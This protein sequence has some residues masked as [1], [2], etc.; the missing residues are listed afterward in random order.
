MTDIIPLEI[1]PT[2]TFPIRSGDGNKFMAR[3]IT[4]W[5][6]QLNSS[7]IYSQ[8]RMS[9][10]MPMDL[11]GSTVIV[12]SN[13]ILCQNCNGSNKL[14]TEIKKDSPC[15]TCNPIKRKTVLIDSSS[16]HITTENYLHSKCNTYKQHETTIK[17]GGINYFNE[18]GIPIEPSNSVNGTQNRQ[19]TDCYNNNCNTTIFKPNN[20]QYA[21]QGGVSSS[22]RI[23][24]LKYNTL[25]NYGAAF[26]SASGAVNINSG[27]YQTEPSPSYYNKFKP[28]QVTPPRK[29]GASNYCPS[30]SIC[31]YE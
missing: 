7:S 15:K 19:I 2:Y 31:M 30:Y 24:R 10:G 8:K 22:S 5:R 29:N 16:N 18:N 23:S 12:K 13:D 26:N 4:Q 14:I 28:Q 17:K 25:N 3:P 27:R 6:K 9:V 11:P 21:Q 20:T 1:I